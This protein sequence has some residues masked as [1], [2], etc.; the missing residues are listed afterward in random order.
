ML[1]VVPLLLAVSVFDAIRNPTIRRLALRNITRRRGEAVLVIIGSML[2]TAIITAALIVGDT[3]GASVRDSARTELGPIDETVRVVGLGKGDAVYDDLRN[4]PLAHTDGLLRMTNTNV[5]VST[6]G[7]DPL[8]SPWG[9]LNEVDF[10]EARSFGDDEGATG[11]RSAGATPEGD[12]AVLNKR[13]ADRLEVGVGDKVRVYGFGNNRDLVVRGVVGSVG[14]AGYGGRGLFVAPGTI[15]RLAAPQA[16]RPPQAYGAPPESLVFVSN[17]GGVF[18]GADHSRPVVAELGRRVADVQGAE[19]LNNKSDLLEIAA[20]IS[21]MFK[22]IFF[23]IGFFSVIAGIVLLSLIFVM[24]ADERKSESGMLRAIGLKRN[25]LVRAFG[26]EG[27]IYSVVSALF[28]VVV[29]IGVGRVVAAVASQLFRGGAGGGF[30]G[31]GLAFSLK[32]ESLTLGFVLGT[33][34]ALATVWTTSIVQGRMNVIRAIRDLPTTTGVTKRSLLRIVLR[35]ASVVFG[36]VLFNTGLA[37]ENWV[38]ILAGPPIAAWCS[39]PLLQMVV[40]RRVSVLIG[41]GI[42][43]LW[44]ATVFVLF[45]DALAQADVG[46]FVVQGVVLVASSVAI[47]ATNDDIAGWAV[48]KLGV[49]R[50]TLAARLGFAYPLARVFRTSLLMFM[51]AIVVFVLTF[52]SVFSNLFGAQAPR[53]ARET[54]A[55]YDIIVDSNWSNP[56][57]APSLLHRPGVA[58]V[59]TLEQAF[60]EWTTKTVTEAERWSMSSFDERL[61][62]RGV[63]KLGDRLARFV[64]DRAVWEAVLQDPTLTVAP[65]FF[66]QRGGPPQGGVEVGD[67]ITARDTVSGRTAVLT[68]AGKVDSDFVR[69]GPMVG[70][71]FMESFM[72]DHTPSRHY[73]AAAHGVDANVLAERLTGKLIDYGVDAATFQDAVSE[74]LDQQ[75]GFFSLMQGYLGIGL[76]IG[77]AGLGVVMVRAVRER[78]RQIGML[79]AMGFPSRVVRQAFLVEASFLTIQGIVLGTVLALITSY[80]MLSYSDAFGGQTLEFQ[81]PVRN[82]VVVSLIALVASLA[83]SAIPAGQAA[84]IKPAVALR[85]AD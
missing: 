63:P 41:C 28:G 85:I 61:L 42:A 7:D 47:V 71:A 19:V 16:G 26:L 83:A 23:A 11:M 45:P 10:D 82:I 36:L 34:I 27:A 15:E 2:G 72:T 35:V 65:D 78:R 33:C 77:I 13:L 24:L 62:A 55:G 44:G 20:D 1:I 31:F 69:N 73:V 52:L 70:Q 64:D 74:Q 17:A 79:R 46:A 67:K 57:P 75:N 49:S 14:V 66:L 81:I 84:R 5:A 29:G 50:R 38:G 9:A 40:S 8:A 37:N 53:F 51:Y 4:T 21:K 76:V 12:E 56:V 6:I 54:A 48:S 43:A 58:Q 68:I 30:G 60:P 22:Q 3:L 80:N 39:I 32:R 25:Q 59:A 18:D